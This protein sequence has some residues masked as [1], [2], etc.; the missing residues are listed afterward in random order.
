MFG[1][2]NACVR[3]KEI[4]E[5]KERDR[6][7]ERERERCIFISMLGSGQFLLRRNIWRQ[8]GGGVM[9]GVNQGS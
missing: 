5:E 4:E 1:Y 8:A 3:K 6:G 2:V 9:P 7:R